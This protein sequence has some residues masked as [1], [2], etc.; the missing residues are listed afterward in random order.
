MKDYK[1]FWT[2]ESQMFY[3]RDKIIS[4]RGNNIKDESGKEYL[5]LNSG[6][7]NVF[8]GHSREEYYTAIKEQL[9]KLEYIPN[10]RFRH[11]AGDELAHRLLGYLPNKYAHVYFTSGG[12][13]AVETAIK[14]ARAHFYENGKKGKRR[15][16]SL[17]ESYHGSTLGAM[18]ASGDPWDR[19][20]FDPLLKDTLKIYPQYCYKCR[21]GLNKGQC[22]Y[23]C[24]KDL[25]YQINFYGAENI[26]ALILEP[27]MGVGGVIIPDKKWLKCV[28]DLCHDNNIIVIFDEISSGSG[29][30][31]NM[32]ACQSYNI[33]PD[34]ILFGKGISNGVQPLAGAIV[35]KEI[36]NSFFSPKREKQFRHGF[37]NSG[38]PV[39]CACGNA[40]LDII[41]KDNIFEV[42]KQKEKEFAQILDLLKN[43][44]YVGE[45]RIKGLMIAIELLNPQTKSELNIPDFDVILRNDGLIA[46]QMCQ[47]VCFM[48]SVC[49]TKEQF[50]KGIEILCRNVER[51]L[52]EVNNEN[53]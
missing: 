27:I 46:S 26:C 10:I 29:R 19:I 30:T 36:F 34:I 17:Y 45:I 41:E 12:A 6:T 48:P 3:D 23:A 44:P 38:H 14:L 21:L 4:C 31:G 20:P 51:Y 2:S 47:V 52:I 32:F 16:I 22:N 33:Y 50:T 40:T 49:T 43:K 28:V 25:E 8:F 53:Y 9:E 15:I 5:D 37:T 35:S 24:L 1:E 11:N 7:W 18:S 42:V 39:A 13:E